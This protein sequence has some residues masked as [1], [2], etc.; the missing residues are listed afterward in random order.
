MP[1]FGLY[2][3]ADFIK[4]AG[5]IFASEDS[6]WTIEVK[7]P[8]S[9]YDTESREEIVVSRATPGFC[10]WH[11]IKGVDRA[12]A[13]RKEREGMVKIAK[14]HDLSA[15]L[16]KTAEFD[17]YKSGSVGGPVLVAVFDCDGCEPSKVVTCGPVK[18]RLPEDEG[19]G[20]LIDV[21]SFPLGNDDCWVDP[22]GGESVV[23]NIQAE[24]VSVK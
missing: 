20:R 12:A 14:N 11:G 3:K 21:G 9:S 22:V 18:I 19:D 4:V 6:A 23:E 15:A 1:L 24:F 2:L 16:L 7:K 5:I 13:E 17:E 10:E 8:R